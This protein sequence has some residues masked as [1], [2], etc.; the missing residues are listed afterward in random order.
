MCNSCRRVFFGRCS[1][2]WWPDATLSLPVFYMKGRNKNG[3]SYL[4]KTLFNLRR[5]LFPPCTRRAISLHNFMDS[6]PSSSATAIPPRTLW[7]TF[8]PATHKSLL[9]FHLAR[10]FRSIC[11]IEKTM[12]LHLSYFVKLQIFV[13]IDLMHAYSMSNNQTHKGVC[14]L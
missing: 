10:L 12:S 8:W 9:S 14:W 6:I 13:E 3:Q 7:F 11:F 5:I 4:P 1:T 2:D